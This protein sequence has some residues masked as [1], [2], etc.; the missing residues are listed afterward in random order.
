MNGI[1]RHR[2]ALGPL[3]LFGLFYTCPRLGRTLVILF[4]AAIL[5]A[6]Y[7]SSFPPS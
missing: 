6:L 7:W 5:L 4:A 1:A 2:S 3:L